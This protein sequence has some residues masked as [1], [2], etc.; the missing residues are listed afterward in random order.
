MRTLV[1][2]LAAVACFADPLPRRSY[3]GVML[4]PEG[5]NVAVA[6]LLPGG[7][8]EKAGW[9][10]GDIV[11]E[12][13]GKKVTSPG[14]VP[15]LSRGRKAGEIIAA[16]L[17]RGGAPVDAPLTLVEMPRETSADFN[18][19]YDA[20][21]VRNALRRTILTAPKGAGRAPAVLLVGGVGCYPADNPI[22]PNAYADI[23]HGLTRAGFATLRVEKSGIGDSQGEPC[24]AVD[25]ETELDGYRAGLKHLATLPN[26]DPEGLFVF[27][28]SMGG[29]TGPVL[30]KEFKLAGVA[31]M[32]TVGTTWLEYELSNTRR[33]RTLRG[34][35]EA[36]L[37]S[38][39]SARAGCVWNQLILKQ[40]MPDCD[41][42][43]A[44]L[45]YMQGV[46]ATDLGAAW[47]ASKTPVL[48]MYGKADFVSG[49]ADHRYL[50]D[51]LNR[52]NPGRA[53]LQIIDDLDHFF[54]RVATQS[55]SMNGQGPRPF[56]LD[57]VPA[58]A[59]WMRARLGGTPDS[60][61]EQTRK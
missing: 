2:F 17:L 28:H 9:R 54:S 47:S 35:S 10:Q 23:L 44:S 15:Q 45:A 39:V 7:P 38:A 55:E 56:N 16:R 11:V 22:A 13:A 46:A 37:D 20:I 1:V 33:Q 41:P 59:E 4:A 36:E 25:F 40:P 19:T 60:T 34:E 50:A 32:A 29:V 8:A 3:V 57:W 24:P 30:A 49:E 48:V 53:T 42:Y 58:M 12:F 21:P 43:P 5:G 18:I 31:V 52:T 14:D 27:G 6:G 51:R 26:V 61:R